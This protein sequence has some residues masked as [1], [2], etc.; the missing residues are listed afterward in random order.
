[1]RLESRGESRPVRRA[2][3]YERAKIAARKDGCEDRLGQFS[4]KKNTTDITI[5]LI[6]ILMNKKRTR[7]WHKERG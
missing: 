3:R 6:L 5:M 2:P 7:N 1:M 4:E